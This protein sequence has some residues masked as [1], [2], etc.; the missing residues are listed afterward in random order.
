VIARIDA[1][2]ATEGYARSFSL[3]LYAQYVG[4]EAAGQFRFTPPTHALRAF[5]R[6]LVELDDEGG[7]KGRADR[8]RANYEI[9][10]AGTRQLGLS[11]LLAPADQSY[12]ITSFHY[13]DHPN[14]DFEVFYQRLSARNFVIYPGKVTDA[15]CFRIGTI[16]R[17]FP[18]DVT[19]L[20]TAITEVLTEM[21][22]EL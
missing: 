17:I 20:L 18:E 13:P 4:L 19:N 16:G 11:E 22:V 2:R 12:I 10:V 6:A 9:L 3:D 14:F 7:I 21:R 15:D 8:Y 1:L 5:H